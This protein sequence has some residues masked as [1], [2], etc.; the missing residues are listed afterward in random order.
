MWY[1]CKSE[2][3]VILSTWL[4]VT[5]STTAVL[6]FFQSESYCSSSFAS[7]GFSSRLPVELWCQV[8]AL[9]W[10]RTFNQRTGTAPFKLLMRPW[11]SKNPLYRHLIEKSHLSLMNPDGP[12]SPPSV[13]YWTGRQTHHRITGHSH[14]GQIYLQAEGAE[15][16][17]LLIEPHTVL[18]GYGNAPVNPHRLMLSGERPWMFL[19]AAQN[20]CLS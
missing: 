16:A 17:E 20:L 10:C 9:Y 18:M 6:S 12:W 14:P 7:G 15:A 3:L 5:W 2:Q 1:F 19:H 4:T 8:S 11:L 13:Q